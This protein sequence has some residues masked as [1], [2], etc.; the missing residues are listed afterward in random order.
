VRG[1]GKE[2]LLD[3]ISKMNTRAL[4]NSRSSLNPSRGWQGQQPVNVPDSF[5]NQAPCIAI[6]TFDNPWVVWIKN[7]IYNSLAYTKWNSVGWNVERG[8]GPNAPG[9]WARFNPSISFDYQNTAWLVWDNAYENNSDDIAFSRWIDTCWT[10]EVQ[11]NLPDSTELDFAPK[12]ACGGGQIWCVWYGGPNDVSSYKIFASRWNGTGWEPEMQVSPSDG[13]QH[14]WCS[15][16][17]DS[18]GRPHVVWC[19]YPHYIV[20]YSYYNGTCW[21]NPILVNDTTRVTAS[22]WADPRIA[23]DCEGHLHVC[24]TGALRGANHRDIFYSKYNGVQW[25]PAI[26]ISQDSLYDEWYSDIA[27]DRP[28]NIWVTFDRQNEGQDQFR[29]YASYFDGNF[30]SNETRLDND[31]S[32]Y[33]ICTAVRLDTNSDPWVVWNGIMYAV[34]EFE[35]FYNRYTSN[36]VE[37]HVKTCELEP[38]ICKILTNPFIYNVKF[39]YQVLFPN[40][41]SINVYDKNGRNIKTL[42]SNFQSKGKYI[43]HWDGT[44]FNNKKISAGIYFCQ[45][46]IG[47]TKDIKKLIF[48]R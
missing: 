43:I 32:Y 6:N 35:I 4:I 30:W 12:I 28:N 9:V 44:D 3:M 19:E 36:A 16:A 1:E 34:D 5:T 41:V 45:L 48:L 17:V 21:A 10:P 40:W 33:D 46:R 29:V 39:W 42:V 25:S 31:V 8:V 38:Y 14:W 7:D 11:V 23:I 13:F 24:W 26:K 15:I 18:T 37:E 27:V 20:Y 2:E 22:P 47:K